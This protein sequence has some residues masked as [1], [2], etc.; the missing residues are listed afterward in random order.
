MDINILKTGL[1]GKVIGMGKL[2]RKLGISSI[3]E[4]VFL[5]CLPMQNLYQLH[6]IV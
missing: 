6:E 1:K 4:N 3:Y 5:H 2:I